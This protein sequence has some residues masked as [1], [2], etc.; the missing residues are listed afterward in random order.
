MQRSHTDV[1]SLAGTGRRCEVRGSSMTDIGD[2]NEKLVLQVIRGAERGIGQAEIVRRSTL[3]RQTVSLITRRLLTE[4]LVETAGRRRTGPGKPPTLLRVVPEARLTLGVHLDP[5]RITVAICDLRAR[6]L[7]VAT[8][9]A[10]SMEPRADI[11][12]IVATIGELSA[13]IDAVLP[14]GKASVPRQLLGIG[15]ASPGALDTVRGVVVDPPWL[16]GWRDVPVVE[17]LQRATALPALLDKDTNAA[18]TGEIWTGHLPAEDTVLYLY[19]GHGVGSAVRANGS[20]HR[21]RASHAGE[22]GHLPLGRGQE[23]C[24]CGRL[25][26]LS[27]DTDAEQL[28][29]RARELQVPI[30]EGAE[31]LEAITA[32]GLAADD[33]HEGARDVIARHGT[34]LG[35]AIVLLIGIHDPQRIIIGGPAWRHLDRFAL[36]CVREVLAGRGLTDS[37]TVESSRLGGDVGAI[38]AASLFLEGE[39]APGNGIAATARPPGRP[40]HGNADR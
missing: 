32:L 15:V 20:I 1:G 33:G 9:D 21:G 16:P 27:R 23:M 5:A 29:R 13:S 25:G 22:I 24:V 26:C 18:L 38:G 14:G 31:V 7:A 8:L 39:L 3:S 2:Y 34:A 36:P 11:D 6:P 10:P 4:G 19:A 30:P 37:A 28:I 17:E 40:S 12:R 35:E